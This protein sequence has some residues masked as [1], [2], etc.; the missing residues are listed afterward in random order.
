MAGPFGIADP[1]LLAAAPVAGPALLP[2]VVMGEDLWTDRCA[3]RCGVWTASL[4]T[5]RKRD[6]PC[7]VFLLPYPKL[8]EL[9]RGPAL[10]IF[11]SCQQVVLGYLWKVDQDQDRD[12]E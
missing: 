3:C 2:E 5:W 11:S 9:E 6:P 8:G 1:V 4:S 10:I 7:R 12:P